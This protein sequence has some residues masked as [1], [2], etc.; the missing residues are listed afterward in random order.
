MSKRKRRRRSARLTTRVFELDGQW[1]LIGDRDDEGFH[2]VR[3]S[4]GEGELVLRME[5]ENQIEIEAA[6]TRRR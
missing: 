3:L 2:A 4:R 5:E 1:Y 6:L